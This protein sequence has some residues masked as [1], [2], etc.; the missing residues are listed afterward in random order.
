[1]EQ[2]AQNLFLTASTPAQHAALAA[3]S[4]DTLDLLETRKAELRVQRD[5]LLPNLRNLGFPIPI[6]PQGA[7]Y[8]YADCSRFTPGCNATANQ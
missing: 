8:L 7:F 5:F 1:M 4:P 3:F 6:A 2:L